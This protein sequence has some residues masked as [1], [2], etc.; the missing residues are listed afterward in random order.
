MFCTQ[1]KNELTDCTCD[2]REERLRAIAEHPNIVTDRCA[3]CANHRK[4]CTCGQY[5]P[6]AGGSG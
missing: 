3:K 4:D 1:C 5:V 6:A 2:D